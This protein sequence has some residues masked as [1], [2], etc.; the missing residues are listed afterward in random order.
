VG[1]ERI[2]LEDHRDVAVLGRDVVDNALADPQRP[3]GDLLEPRDHP[4]GGR[5]AASGRPDQ[6]HEL[7]IADLDVH[8]LDG[9]EIAVELVDVLER[10]VR[11]GR[12]PPAWS[13]IAGP[14]IPVAQAMSR[15]KA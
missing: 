9:V 5:L 15:P 10:H 6:D 3:A 13:A 4:E 1:I 8:V 12:S 11:H 2:A 14:C 7:A